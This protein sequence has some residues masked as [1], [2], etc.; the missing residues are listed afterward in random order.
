MSDIEG[1]LTKEEQFKKLKECSD[2]KDMSDWNNWHEQPHSTNMINLSGLNLSG[3]WLKGVNFSYANLEGSVLSFSHLEGADLTGAILNK[4][5]LIETHLE[6]DFNGKA[7]K[8]H[9]AKFEGTN[10]IKTH[11]QGAEM[12]H[13]DLKTAI[14]DETHFEEANLLKGIFFNKTQ[15]KYLLSVHFNGAT[16]TLANFTSTDL[17]KLHFEKSS[18]GKQ[19]CLR[20][21]IFKGAGIGNTNFENADMNHVDLTDSTLW[22]VNFE[23]ADLHYSILEG[24]SISGDKIKTNL[25]GADFTGAT[26]NGRTKIQEC[27]IDKETNFTIVGL[28]SA[29]IDPKLLAALKTNIRRITWNKYYDEQ[30]KLRWG[31]IKIAPMRFFWWLSDYG[32]S[33]ERIFLSI[34]ISILLF[35]D[36]Y[37][38]IGSYAPNVI[39][40]PEQGARMSRVLPVS[41]S[42]IRILCFAIS[43]M[44]TLGFGGINVTIDKAFPRLSNFAFLAVT[45]NLVFGYLFLSVLVTRFGILFQSQAPEQK[46]KKNNNLHLYLIALTL[47]VLGLAIFNKEQNT[48]EI[49][50]CATFVCI[51]F[52]VI[53]Y[54]LIPFMLPK[55]RTIR[56]AKHLIWK[57]RSWFIVKPVPKAKTKK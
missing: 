4:A 18:T 33:S 39:S 14:L 50:T 3:M 31:K 41:N 25:K 45:L 37:L 23:S 53:L 7:T 51:F 32:S 35:T 57:F 26:V 43:T 20:D 8:L 11:L 2:K 49:F 10:L 52:L 6:R 27:D 56:F 55:Y 22:E 24:T 47:L 38:I 16:L 42:Y 54:R 28:D 34:L 30:K 19:T 13:A 46:T 48:K 21:A 5:I 36:V 17:S 12:P 40:L 29:G 1:P 9:G 44:V 15:K